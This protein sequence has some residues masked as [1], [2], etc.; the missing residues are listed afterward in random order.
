MLVLV[1]G[2]TASGKSTIGALLAARL[3]FTFHD[4]DDYHPPQNLAKMAADRALDDADRW[5]WLE[6]LSQLAE[7]WEA[8]GGA[9]LACSALKQAYRDVLLQRV[10]EPRVLYLELA[11]ADA[12]QRLERRRGLHAVV[13]DFT[14]ILDGQYRD[15]EPPTEALTVPAL[16]S[17][18]QII[19]RAL[20]Y[21]ASARA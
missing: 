3:G 17:P 15:L 7:S 12:E 14:G 9:V 19:Q 21:V 5:P 8:E 20:A 11:R 16:L 18:E 6:R 2:V 1:M 10:L 13:C 4:A